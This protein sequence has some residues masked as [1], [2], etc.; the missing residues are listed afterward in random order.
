LRCSSGHVV[1]ALILCAGCA[2]RSPEPRASVDFEPWSGESDQRARLVRTDHYVIHTTIDD[3][4]LLATL[5]QVM[6]GALTQYQQFTPGVR[7]SARP[8]ECFVFATRPQWARFTAEKTGDDAT[9]YLKINKGGYT[10]RDWYVAYFIGDVG[11]YAVAAHE[12]WHQYVAR[13][14]K[15]RLPPFLEEGIASMFETITWSGG[16]PRWTLSVN[17]VRATRLRR[18]IERGDLWPLESLIT[19]H[20][21]DVVNL[22]GERIETFYAQNWAFAQFLWE[23][24]DQRYRAAF[25]RMLGDLA[26]GAASPGTGSRNAS[27][28]LWNPASARPMLEH[29]LGMPL[30][31]IERAYLAYVARIARDRREHD[32]A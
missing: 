8:M 17:P 22:P 21:G 2:S 12:G 28:L 11:T 10:I 13:H 4:Q 16:Q 29:Y 19:M 1:L 32:D 26:A 7:L 25:Q 27:A 5:A 31:H 3:E 14:F 30:D 24:E 23:A 9:V 6:E 18:A 20:A 15:S